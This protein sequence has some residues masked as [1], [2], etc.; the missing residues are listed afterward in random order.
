M[1]AAGIWYGLLASTKGNWRERRVQ[2]GTEKPRPLDN[3]VPKLELNKSGLHF[4]KF[5]RAI[6]GL[7]Q[8]SAVLSEET[9]LQSLPSDDSSSTD[10]LLPRVM[11]VDMK[12]LE[13]SP[14]AYIRFADAVGAGAVAGHIKVVNQGL[15]LENNH[16][17]ATV[18][19]CLKM[20]DLDDSD[21]DSESSGVDLAGLRVVSA[22][23]RHYSWPVADFS[24]FR[25]QNISG[26]QLGAALSTL[27][28]VTALRI[29]FRIPSRFSFHCA[30]L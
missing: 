8:A 6:L 29:W 4:Q 2:L 5:E 7:I 25:F 14:Q 13:Y 19:G 26:A 24:S 17:R 21:S 15:T 30:C 27:T 10:V 28:S 18:Q 20:P 12:G 1:Q 9:N 23:I 11:E 22:W 3:F 16:R